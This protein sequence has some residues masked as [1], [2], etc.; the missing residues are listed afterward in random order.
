MAMS[1]PR[2]GKFQFSPL[3]E[4]RPCRYEN[5]PHH[6]LYFNSRPCVRGDFTLI[7][8]GMRWLVFQ[9]SPLREGRLHEDF[10]LATTDVF[11]FSPLRE[12]RPCASGGGTS[13]F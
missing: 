4:G 8:A 11:Q 9:F 7:I 3:R 12:G 6:Q 10:S 1:H 5:D 13:S 2:S